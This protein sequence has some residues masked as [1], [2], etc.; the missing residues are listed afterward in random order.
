ML[1]LH[2][3]DLSGAFIIEKKTKI[4]TVAKK[5]E[6]VVKVSEI[7]YT[8]SY[9]NVFTT[10]RVKFTTPRALYSNEHI[11]IDLGKDLRDVNPMAERINVQLFREYNGQQVNLVVAFDGNQYLQMLF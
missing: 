7:Q 3:C 4:F 11:L 1:E 10:L 6:K 5:Y 8:N 9:A 2:I